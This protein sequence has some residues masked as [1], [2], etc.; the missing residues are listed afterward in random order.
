M[1]SLH[2]IE[3]YSRILRVDPLGL[4]VFVV[5]GL[6]AFGATI[7]LLAQSVDAPY[8]DAGVEASGLLV[9]VGV[10]VPSPGN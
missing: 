6:V 2:R 9:R 7:V 1:Q 8:V 10:F 4:G 3:S 5:L